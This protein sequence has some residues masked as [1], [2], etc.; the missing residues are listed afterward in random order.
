MDL[1]KIKKK[2]RSFCERGG[3]KSNTHIADVFRRYNNFLKRCPYNT[4]LYEFSKNIY[5]YKNTV[6]Q[7]FQTKSPKKLL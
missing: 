3:P 5:G 7:V 1:S 2:K 6:K 4:H